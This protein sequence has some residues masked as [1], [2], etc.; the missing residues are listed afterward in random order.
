MKWQTNRLLKDNLK[1]TYETEAGWKS[2]PFTRQINRLR[3]NKLEIKKLCDL[4]GW[5]PPVWDHVRPPEASDSTQSSCPAALEHHLLPSRSDL[6]A[7]WESLCERSALLRKGGSFSWNSFHGKSSIC[8]SL[9]LLMIITH[10]SHSYELC[11]FLSTIWTTWWSVW[12]L[13]RDT[14]TWAP[15][16]KCSQSPQGARNHM[17]PH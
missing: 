6:G 13:R 1:S 17:D 9:L 12:W 15:H 4:C 11:L 5:F 7:H 3:V 8:F 2:C 14:Q 10:V 16:M